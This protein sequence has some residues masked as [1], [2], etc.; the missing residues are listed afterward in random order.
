MT[1]QGQKPGFSP[2]GSQECFSS[3]SVSMYYLGG[4]LHLERIH[5]GLDRLAVGLDFN[6]LYRSLGG[7]PL[8]WIASIRVRSSA[9]SGFQ[10]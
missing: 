4:S 2:I 9:K 10:E 1:N 5:Q 6:E 8:I 3:H 7:Y